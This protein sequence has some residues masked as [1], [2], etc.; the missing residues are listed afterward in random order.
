MLPGAAEPIGEAKL[1]G[2]K[3]NGMLCS[4][5]ELGLGRDHAGLMTL[6][7]DFTP[8]TSFRQALGLDD[9]QLVVDV[10]PNRGELLSHLGVARELAPG[11][12]DGIKLPRSE[13]RRV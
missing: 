11:G 12:E 3:S 6:R 13:E 5:R 4:A 7:G 2:E 9:W 10:T 8:G 1:R